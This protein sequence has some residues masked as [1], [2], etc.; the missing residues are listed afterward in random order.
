MTLRCDNCSAPA[1]VV[2]RVLGDQLPASRPRIDL[3][4][5]CHAAIERWLA[6]PT[7]SAGA[8]EVLD[9]DQADELEAD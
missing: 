3:C 7:R 6:P 8:A 1:E 5:R 9:D 4:R 2:L